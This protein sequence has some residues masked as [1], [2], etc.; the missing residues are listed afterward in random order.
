MAN[1]KILFTTNRIYPYC[2]ACGNCLMNII[3][4]ILE[5][6]STIEIFVLQVDYSFKEQT[7]FSL[8]EKRV[9]IITMPVEKESKISVFINKFLFFKYPKTHKNLVKTFKKGVN[10]LKKQHFFEAIID[11]FTPYDN[12][13]NSIHSNS[14]IKKA[15]IMFDTFFKMKVKQSDCFFKR[16][17]KSLCNHSAKNVE[18]RIKKK[19]DFILSQSDM[20]NNLLV[21]DPVP[22]KLPLLRIVDCLDHDERNVF[23]YAGSFYDNLRVPWHAISIITNLIKNYKEFNDFTFEIFCNKEYVKKIN[24]LKIDCV[25]AYDFLTRKQLDEKLSTS[26]YLVNIGNLNSELL[27]SKLIDYLS[28]KKVILNFNSGVCLHEGDTS[29]AISELKCVINIDSETLVS[30]LCIQI[31]NVNSNLKFD[32][33]QFKD[34]FGTGRDVA[35]YILNSICDL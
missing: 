16:L 2:D 27:P 10:D 28:F 25:K 29:K 24:D 22:F 9:N 7:T 35:L 1:K 26:K 17:A 8:F 23:T 11:T 12:V 21:I 33:L 34:K 18:K 5:L 3:Q 30:D 15:L 4:Q 31:L 14:Q 6:N 20:P 19:Y 13:Y 32:T